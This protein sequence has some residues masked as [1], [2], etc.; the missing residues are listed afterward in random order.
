MRTP[1]P[2]IPRF[3]TIFVSAIPMKFLTLLCCLQLLTGFGFA[4]PPAATPA[5]AAITHT[6]SPDDD[7]FA[8]GLFFIALIA[9]TAVFILTGLGIALG[10][11]VAGITAVLAVVGIVSTSAVFGFLKR[12]TSAAI[13]ALLFQGAALAGVPCGIAAFWVGRQFAHVHFSL[14]SWVVWGALSGAASGLLIAFTLNFAW[15]R[16]YEKLA[17]RLRPTSVM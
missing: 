5:P 15:G 9:I 16:C 7:D 14:A 4:E 13:R 17:A 2:S 1:Q 12:R 10:C 3:F 8:P 6:A 11:V